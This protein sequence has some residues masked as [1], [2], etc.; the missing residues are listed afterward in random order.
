MTILL[1]SVILIDFLN[2]IPEAQAY[3]DAHRAEAAISVVTT[4][5]VL[6][7]VDDAGVPA[8]VRFLDAFPLLLIDGTTALQAARLRHRFGWRLPDAFQ[9]ALAQQHGLRLATRNTKD[10][11]PAV[12]PF[13]V[14]PYTI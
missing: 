4:A 6:A 10:F 8:T 12:H 7:G 3:V 2:A 9:A 1:D 11:D 14:V 5:E 13:V